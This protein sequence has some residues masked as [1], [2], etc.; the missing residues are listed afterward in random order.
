MA[1][2][3][4]FAKLFGPNRDYR[5]LEGAS[6]VTLGKGDAF[7]PTC[8]WWLAELSMLTYVKEHAFIRTQLEQ[9][10]AAEIRIIDA[11][12]AGVRV[13]IAE[14]NSC[15]IIV[16]RGTETD[17]L[18]NL[19]TDLDALP[20][21]WEQGGLAHRGFQAALQ[22]VWERIHDSILEFSGEDVYYGGHSMGGALA[23]LAASRSQKGRAVYTFGTPRVG[24]SQFAESFPLSV[25]RIVHNNDIVTEIPLPAV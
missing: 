15:L 6:N 25:Y 17:S 21:K 14:V 2:E 19:Q 16:F 3:L 8:A 20:V 10:Q 23:L 12:E 13:I 18:I 7:D 4:S 22:K 11:E 1:E 5:Y 24:D 9:V